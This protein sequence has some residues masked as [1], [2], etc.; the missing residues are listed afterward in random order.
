MKLA[1]EIAV[2]HRLR[3]PSEA[4]QSAAAEA[5]DHVVEQ[6]VGGRRIVGLV[7]RHPKRGNRK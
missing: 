6:R 1:A 5:E 2:D 3:E 7:L 4:H